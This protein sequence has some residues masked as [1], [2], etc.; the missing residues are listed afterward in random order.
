MLSCATD[1]LTIQVYPKSVT[2]S[3]FGIIFIGRQEIEK[4]LFILLSESSND[5]LFNQLT[6]EEILL[7]DKSLKLKKCNMIHVNAKLISDNYEFAKAKVLGIHNSIGM[8][9]R[10]GL[11]NAGHIRAL[12]GFSFRPILAQQSIR[13]L[14]RTQR[15][16]RKL[17]MRLSGP[18]FRKGGKMDSVPMPI[19]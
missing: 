19:I 2:D 15:T 14:T 1:S 9:D 10:I 3:K 5:S 7:T 12:K 17:K 11:A 18:L 8:G 16:L 13:E 4:S 6:G